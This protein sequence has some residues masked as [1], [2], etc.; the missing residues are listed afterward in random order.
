[1]AARLAACAENDAASSA[2]VRKER[3]EPQVS[4]AGFFF[5]LI[6]SERGRLSRAAIRAG[7]R[8][9]ELMPSAASG[10]RRCGV[11]GSAGALDQGDI[12]SIDGTVFVGK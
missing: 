5:F 6:E 8:R 10:H 2:S 11:E 7:G 1:M 12:L 4:V 9:G 3:P